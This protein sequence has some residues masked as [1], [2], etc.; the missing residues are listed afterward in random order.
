M[1]LKTSYFT[2]GYDHRHVLEL[3]DEEVIALYDKTILKITAP[4]PRSLMFLYCGAEWSH[5]YDE[6]TAL[7][8]IPKY[9]YTVVEIG[10]QVVRDA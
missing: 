9:G 3:P 2:F 7:G 5:E 4:S 8:L 6:P 1:L 10:P